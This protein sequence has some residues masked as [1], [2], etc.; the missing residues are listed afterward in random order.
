MHRTKEDPID[1]HMVEAYHRRSQREE[2]NKKELASHVHTMS[3]NNYD[4]EQV[5][6]ST[7]TKQTLLENTLN[8]VLKRNMDIS[9]VYGPERESQRW[10]GVT[11]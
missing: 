7:T 9:E 6:K 10:S 4:Q 1:R 8:E 11:D 3:G 5:D 2:S